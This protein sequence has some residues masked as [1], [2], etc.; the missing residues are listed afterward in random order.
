MSPQMH[1]RVIRH[2]N[3]T[4]SDYSY[5]SD[6]GYSDREILAFWNRDAKQGKTGV[7][8]KHAFDVVGYL[9]GACK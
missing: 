3:F 5:L 4:V 7:T 9:N 2:P 6:K 1:S 8:H